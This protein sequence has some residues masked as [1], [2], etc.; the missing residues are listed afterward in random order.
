MTSLLHYIRDLREIHAANEV[1]RKISPGIFA[2]NKVRKR[3]FVEDSDLLTSLSL[4]QSMTHHDAMT[5][6]A[7]LLGGLLK[8]DEQSHEENIR[9]GDISAITAS[10]GK[11]IGNLCQ[12]E[13]YDLPTW[14]IS[15]ESS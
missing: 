1:C 6:T 7:E 2:L 3:V 8:G 5:E 11:F 14:L 4:L 10:K 12:V 15:P 9:I 13:I